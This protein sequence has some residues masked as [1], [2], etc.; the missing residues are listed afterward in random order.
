M[1]SLLESIFDD[2]LA[3]N[4]VFMDRSNFDDPDSDVWKFFHIQNR[5]AA[6][7]TKRSEFNTDRKSITIKADVS[8]YGREKYPFLEKY[9]LNVLTLMIG[10][11]QCSGPHPDPIRN[12]AGFKSLNVGNLIIDGYC[13]EISDCHFN[14]LSKTTTD[15]MGLRNHTGAPVRISW[16]DNL[17]FK[18]TSI[19]FSE[20]D[21]QY[22]MIRFDSLWDFPDLSGLKSDT[23][24][25]IKLYDPSLFDQSDIKSKL[26][27]FFGSGTITTEIGITKSKSIRNIVAI[28][29]NLQ[30]YKATDP[31]EFKPVGKI[32]DL[33]NI[34]GFK[35]LNKIIM[36]NNNVNIMFF[37]TKFYNDVAKNIEQ[38]ARYIRLNNLKAAK[39]QPIEEIVDRILQTKTADGWVVC[40]EKSY[41]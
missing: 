35:N 7:L 18:D 1:K 21:Q 5:D 29:N 39:E 22:N 36:S 33:I 32:N 25:C 13:K 8:L 19:E 17:K 6:F 28:A 27:K 34:S 41:F 23:A 11:S 9:D 40:I 2:D 15:S 4:G 30:K 31:L 20:T 10:N 38:H 37:N 26:D 3:S 16:V 14:I 24:I 12:N